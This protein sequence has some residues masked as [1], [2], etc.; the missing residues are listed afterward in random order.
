MEVVVWA[1]CALSLPADLPSADKWESFGK[2]E[3]AYIQKS[4][5]V[6]VYKEQKL[7]PTKEVAAVNPA[8]NI[9]TTVSV[10]PIGASNQ[11]YAFWASVAE[12]ISKKCGGATLESTV[13]IVKLDAKGH[14]IR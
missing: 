4:W 1:A 2:N 12:S 8:H 6:S 3:Y 10:E 5:K 14:E 7:T 11:A 13:G 9:A